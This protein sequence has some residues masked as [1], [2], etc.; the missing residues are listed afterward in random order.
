VCRKRNTN[1]KFKIM[2]V[3]E[4]EKVKRLKKDSS[5]VVMFVIMLEDGKLIPLYLVTDLCLISI[6]ENIRMWRQ[7]LIEYCVAE[8][9]KYSCITGISYVE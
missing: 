3:R 6:F 9:L 2:F 5:S 1:L 4:F 8:S 7:S